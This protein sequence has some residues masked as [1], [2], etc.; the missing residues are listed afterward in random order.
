MGNYLNESC[1]EKVFEGE[2]K[3]SFQML[4]YALLLSMEK[5]SG[6]DFNLAVYQVRNLYSQGVES[7]YCPKE[8][9]EAFG[10]R[11]KDLIEEIF[12]KS[13]AFD[14]VE[15][16]SKTCDYCPAKAICGR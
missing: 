11:L 5:D 4:V 7:K 16:G 14:S 12:E 2:K 8:T 6:K 1:L 15:A 10:G 9:V 3:T 13:V